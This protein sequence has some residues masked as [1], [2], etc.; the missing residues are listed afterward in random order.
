MA[1]SKKS[2][3]L[4]LC[5]WEGTDKPRRV[6]FVA[7][8][9]AIE[10]QLGGHIQNDNLHLNDTRR[11]R[12]DTPTEVR[13]YTGTGAASRTILFGFSPSAVIVFAVDKPFSQATT[14]C[15]KQ[16]AGI[17]AGGQNSLGVTLSTAQVTVRQTQTAPSDGSGMASLNESGV[18][19]AVLAF[20]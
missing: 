15:T 18:T 16:Y 9:E 12:L 5:L 1:A 13:T 19:Y 7:D 10:S 8:N 4:G 6:D 20:R 2:T 11:K 17:A 3:V 14:G